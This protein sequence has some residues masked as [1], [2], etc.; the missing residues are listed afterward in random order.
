MSTKYKY[1]D[2]GNNV[3][4]PTIEKTKTNNTFTTFK[5][6]KERVCINQTR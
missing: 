2:K 6:I 1:D 5:N 4:F 3:K